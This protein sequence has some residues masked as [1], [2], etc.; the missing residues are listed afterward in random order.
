MERRWKWGNERFHML[1]VVARRVNRKQVPDP[2]RNLVD[3]RSMTITFSLSPRFMSVAFD[4]RI[5]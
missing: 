3:W 5:S 1:S 4:K 2:C